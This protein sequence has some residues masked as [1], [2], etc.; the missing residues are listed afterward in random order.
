MNTINKVNESAGSY[1]TKQDVLKILY[2]FVEEM[3][4]KLE[5]PT[6]ETINDSL[7]DSLKSSITFD[8]YITVDIVENNKTESTVDEDQ[9][10]E[11]LVEFINERKGNN[12]DPL[13]DF[14]EQVKTDIKNNVV[15]E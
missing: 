10:I 15:F 4:D 8:D 7:R 3:E 1:F 14:L 11:S 13:Y 6:S 2:R 9:L 5:T 12:S